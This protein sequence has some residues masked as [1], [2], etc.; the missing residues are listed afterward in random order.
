MSTSITMQGQIPHFSAVFGE[1]LETSVFCFQ[2]HIHSIRTDPIS[3]H[4]CLK[5]DVSPSLSLIETPVGKQAEGRLCSNKS[6]IWIRKRNGK[7][8][9][10]A[11]DVALKSKHY[12]NGCL[13]QKSS[14]SIRQQETNAICTYKEGWSFTNVTA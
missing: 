12:F 13:G 14:L 4:H 10:K 2:A 5:S 11:A 1:F 8:K 9:P 6:Q 3:H 7:R